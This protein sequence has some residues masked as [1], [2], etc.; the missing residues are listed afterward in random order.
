MGIIFSLLFE[1][2]K[3]FSAINIFD[4]LFG[5]NWSPQRAFVSDASAITALEYENLKGAFGSVPLFAG[6]AFIALI[7]MLVAVPFR[8]LLLLAF[9]LARPHFWAAPRKLSWGSLPAPGTTCRSRFFLP[10][11]RRLS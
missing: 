6:T 3:F 2:L 8:P 11:P 1:S 4:F 9:P 10:H 5:M 7:A